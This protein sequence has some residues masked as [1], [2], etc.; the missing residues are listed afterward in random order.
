MLISFVVFTLVNHKNKL[1]T[2]QKVRW[3][4]FDI[5]LV[6]PQKQSARMSKERWIE[7]D[8]STSKVSVG[9]QLDRS[10]WAFGFE[11]FR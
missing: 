6:K 3:I 1:H 4:E 2:S 8:I 10:E 9:L 5:Q 7:G 11:T